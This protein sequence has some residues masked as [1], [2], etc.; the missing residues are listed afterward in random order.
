M[1]DGFGAPTYIHN[2]YTFEELRAK[3]AGGRMDTYL[4]CISRT[5]Q[6]GNFDEDCNALKPTDPFMTGQQTSLIAV[7]QRCKANYQQRQWDEGAFLAYDADGIANHI[8]GVQPPAPLP[9]PPGSVGACLLKAR[10]DQVICPAF[11]IGGFLD[12]YI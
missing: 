11:F 10:A 6:L 3:L 7:F 2:P 5:S 8:R 4:R 12:F 1:L 9:A